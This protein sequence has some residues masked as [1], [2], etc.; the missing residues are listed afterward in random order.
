MTF[1]IFVNRIDR[2]RLK[3]TS[4]YFVN[5]I[6]SIGPNIQG[7]LFLI[8]LRFRIHKFALSAEIA[9]MHRLVFIQREQRFKKK[10]YGDSMLLRISLRL[11]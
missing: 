4:G 11:P 8:L 3:Y 10:Y 2:S 1:V 7:N 6:M 5:E 9:K